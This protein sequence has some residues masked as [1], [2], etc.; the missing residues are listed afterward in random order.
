MAVV[1]IT[2]GIE[3]DQRNPPLQTA[4]Y[5]IWRS[6]QLSKLAACSTM[7]ST[8]HY[9]VERAACSFRVLVKSL[10]QAGSM[11]YNYT[12]EADV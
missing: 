9:H 7:L 11:F 1:S 3:D 2:K 12:L 6:D 5:V 10:K 4:H 8:R